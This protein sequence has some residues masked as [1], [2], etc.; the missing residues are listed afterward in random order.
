MDRRRLNPSLTVSDEV[1]E[2]E[3]L[4]CQGEKN[5]RGKNSPSMVRRSLPSKRYPT[6][7]EEPTSAKQQP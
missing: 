7:S 1:G 5:P 4:H 6:R 3:P 2:E